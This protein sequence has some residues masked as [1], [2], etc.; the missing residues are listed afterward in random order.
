MRG[1]EIELMATKD[2]SREVLAGRLAEGLGGTT[3][4]VFYP[5]SEISTNPAVQ[6]YETLTLAFQVLDDGGRVFALLADDI[7]LNE[8][9][10]H[11]AEGAAGFYRILSAHKPI[12]DLIETT[13]SAEDDINDVLIPIAELYGS[14]VVH[15]EQG[16]RAVRCRSGIVATALPLAG[17]R[18]RACEIISPPL[19]GDAVFLRRYLTKVLTVSRELGFFI[20]RE[21]ATHVHFDAQPLRS[22]TVMRNLA[23]VLLRFGRALRHL[24]E[25]NDACTRLGTWPQS[26]VDLVV[27]PRFLGMDW[28][29][30]ARAMNETS[31]VKWCDFNVLNIFDPFA[32]KRT[33][34]VRILKTTWDAERLVE[35][36][37]MFEKLL[38]WSVRLPALPT[39]DARGDEGQAAE[40]ALFL[41]T[42]QW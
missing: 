26:F 16:V 31:V 33:F 5:Q 27:S 9:I 42:G 41:E 39:R 7:T 4:R 18:Q 37:N 25:T 6:G 2:S 38:Q 19:G 29:E 32:T 8:D 35:Q 36:S 34:E 20:P 17:D 24:C 13:C 22:A 1:F 23:L 10:D 12:L 40:L 28:N 11:D 30:A 15:G 21:S 3:R 14:S